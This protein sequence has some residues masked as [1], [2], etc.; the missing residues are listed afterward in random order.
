MTNETEERIEKT[1]LNI[2]QEMEQEIQIIDRASEDLIDAEVYDAIDALLGAYTAQL[3][4]RNAPHVRLSP[5]KKQ[6]YEAVKAAC[7]ARIT[8]DSEQ[9]GSDNS[10]KVSVDAIVECLKRLR[11]SIKRWNTV[12]GRRGYIEFTANFFL[13]LPDKRIR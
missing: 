11:I 3:R 4:G 2:L 7:E 5:L 6:I 12:N 1:Y 9:A 8:R 10:D 13:K